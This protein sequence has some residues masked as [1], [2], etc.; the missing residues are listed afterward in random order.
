MREKRTIQASIF[1]YYPEHE[2]EPNSRQCQNGWMKIL[3]CWI[4]ADVKNCDVEKICSSGRRGI[5]QTRM[6]NN[7]T[8]V[9]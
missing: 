8:F 6:V 9:P 3:T 1:E 5:T 2:I 4:A 7:S